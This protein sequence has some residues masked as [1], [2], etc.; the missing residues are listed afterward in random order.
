MKLSEWNLLIDLHHDSYRPYYA[1]EWPP[2]T[3]PTDNLWWEIT[4]LVKWW[5]RVASAKD[6]PSFDFSDSWFRNDN[7]NL[8]RFFLNQNAIGNECLN[9]KAVIFHVL[10]SFHYIW[11]QSLQVFDLQVFNYQLVLYGIH[12]VCYKSGKQLKTL[13]WFFWDHFQYSSIL[14]ILNNCDHLL[15]IRVSVEVLYLVI[16]SS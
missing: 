6:L 13:G 11:Y 9:L 16:N 4:Y 15:S 12:S 8:T 7:L 14:R 5:K 10:N 2:L 1:W 3:R